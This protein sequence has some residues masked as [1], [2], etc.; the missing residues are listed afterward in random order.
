MTSVHNVTLIAHKSL[1][2]NEGKYCNSL[3]PFS[4]FQ[5]CDW[6]RQH[7]P[8][9]LSMIIV[10]PSTESVPLQFCAQSCVN[11]YKMELFCVEVKEQLRKIKDE[12]LQIPTIPGKNGAGSHKEKK[13]LITP[14]LWS[15]GR[16]DLLWIL[17][18][19]S[20]SML[21]NLF[22]RVQINSSYYPPRNILF[23]R[24]YQRKFQRTKAYFLMN[25]M[26]CKQDKLLITKH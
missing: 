1:N 22:L 4:L 23:N 3:I 15:E 25:L 9:D 5:T 12:N 10:V 6:C 2:W 21:L 26:L 7:F 16:Q 17:A 13:I 24:F 18:F 8:S 14:E 11:K 19:I 20:L